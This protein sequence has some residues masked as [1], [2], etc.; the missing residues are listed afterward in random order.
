MDIKPL[1]RCDMS[2]GVPWLRPPNFRSEGVQKTVDRY[3]GPPRARLW[4][5][6]TVP[7]TPHFVQHTPPSRRIAPAIQASQL[8]DA[9]LG[10]ALATLSAL[11]VTALYRLLAATAA[12]R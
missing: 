7:G 4:A 12:Q 9:P 8:P 2:N 6:T 10:R 5:P 11:G 3:N 1:L